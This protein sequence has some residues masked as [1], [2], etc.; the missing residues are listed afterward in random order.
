MA[1]SSIG[2]SLCR[3]KYNFDVVTKMGMLGLKQASTP[4]EQ[5]HKL[6]S[7][8]GLFFLES[9]TYQLFVGRLIYLTNT[10]QD[11]TYDVYLLS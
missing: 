8:I 11:L 10:H 4:I 7:D 9:S 5:N 1:R 6:A 3:R 2:F